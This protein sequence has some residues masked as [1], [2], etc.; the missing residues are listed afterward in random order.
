MEPLV[1]KD[2]V[3]A[4]GEGLAPADAATWGVNIFPAWCA[5]GTPNPGLNAAPKLLAPRQSV[6][7][8]SGSEDHALTPL[9]DAL[10]NQANVFPGS[11]PHNCLLTF[12]V[13]A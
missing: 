4:N 8:L 9:L 1:A 2:H 6:A 12:D 11:F 3:G 7:L 5:V 10:P 13:I